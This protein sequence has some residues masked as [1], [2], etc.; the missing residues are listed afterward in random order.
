MARAILDIAKR[1]SSAARRT[2]S[3]EKT[4]RSNVSSPTS[5]LSL[6]RC[7]IHTKGVGNLLA[8]ITPAAIASP[9]F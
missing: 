8:R 2:P 4:T 1:L 5:I 3:V 9:S 7:S 6:G